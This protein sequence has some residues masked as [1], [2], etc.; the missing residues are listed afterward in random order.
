MRSTRFIKFIYLLSVPLFISSL[1]ASAQIRRIGAGFTFSTPV[2]F[3]YGETGNPGLVLKTWI[4]LNK[5][6]TLHISPSLT[7]FNRY[8][9][10][11]GYS[12]LSNYMFHGDLDAMFTVF[13]EGNVKA[14]AFAG[15]N[16]TYLTSDYKAVAISGNETI[17]DATDFAVGANLGA[18]LE[19]R[20]ASKW[21]FLI[22]G[23]Y[24]FSNYSQFVI[25]VQGVYY[26]KGRRRSYTRR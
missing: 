8:R 3:N 26:F 24:T 23:K 16:A 2:D 6:H 22:S 13:Q 18:A 4:I 11:T 9:A 10:E 7:A 25:S 17:S 12:I 15:G 1:D 20:M 14:L 5:A 21:D 19:L